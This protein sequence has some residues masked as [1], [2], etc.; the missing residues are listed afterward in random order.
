MTEFLVFALTAA[1]VNCA[2]CGIF[3][4]EGPLNLK[5]YASLGGGTVF[6]TVCASA[7]S[8]VLRDGLLVPM[9]LGYL[10]VPGYLLIAAAM[11]WLLERLLNAC[12]LAL[13][14]PLP[15]TAVNSAAL[16]C[17]VYHKQAG[18]GFTAAVRSGLGASVLFA[19]LLVV[20]AAIVN[21]L[22]GEALPRPVRGLPVL[23]LCG[24][25]ISLA[26]MGLT[27]LSF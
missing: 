27:G 6:V 22:D 18:Y 21:R 15:L 10:S 14:V 19:V 17:L 13:S 11:V 3:L 20:L 23:L 1:L 25:L 7:A 5:A 12:G 8:A 9:G 26:L 4:K 24:A 16:G 2:V